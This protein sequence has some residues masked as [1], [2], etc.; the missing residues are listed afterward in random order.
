MKVIEIKKII[1]KILD[2]NKAQNI[3][4]INLKNKSF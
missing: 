1:E 4:S 3:T 2:D